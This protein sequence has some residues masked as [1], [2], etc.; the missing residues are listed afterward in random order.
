M[1][2]V[3]LR[4]YTA[5]QSISFVE[6]R[7]CRSSSYVYRGDSCDCVLAMGFRSLRR[8][9]VLALPAAPLCLLSPM[10]CSCNG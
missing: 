6:I 3:R 8:G 4:S 7:P 5:V 9:A 10:L 1:V 2:G